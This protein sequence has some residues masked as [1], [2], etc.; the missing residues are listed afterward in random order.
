MKIISIGGVVLDDEDLEG[1]VEKATDPPYEINVEYRTR[2]QLAPSIEDYSYQESERNLYIQPKF[3]T[4]PDLETINQSVREF[5]AVTG[6]LVEIIGEYQ[7]T[8]YRNDVL[9]RSNARPYQNGFRLRGVFL[10]PAWEATSVTTSS[11]NPIAI[12]GN[13]VVR[14]LITI[15]DGDAV[16]RT[17]LTITDQT[18]EGID[19][20]MITTAI[21]AGSANDILIVKDGMSVPFEFASNRVYFRVGTRIGRPTVVDIYEGSAIN[22]TV[23][24]DAM[25]AGGLTLDSDIASGTFKPSP[26]DPYTHPRS[27][28]MSWL[29]QITTEHD[30]SIPYRFGYEDGT[31]KLIDSDSTGTQQKMNND[32]DSLVLT[33]PVEMDEISGIEIDLATGFRAGRIAEDSEDVE[34]VMRVIITDADGNLIPDDVREWSDGTVNIQSTYT[35]LHLSQ[36]TWPVARTD[37][38]FYAQWTFGAITFPYT[39]SYETLEETFQITTPGGAKFATGTRWNLD[40][41]PW[42]FPTVAAQFLGCTVE[43]GAT[44]VYY[45]RWA[46]GAFQGADI[47]DLTMSLNPKGASWI[48]DD[49]GDVPVVVH[50]DAGID[51]VIVFQTDWVDPVT[52]EVLDGSQSDAITDDP[53]IG[54]ARAVVKY[55]TRDS[56][57]PITAYSV[58][59]TGTSDGDVTSDPSAGAPVAGTDNEVTITLPTISIPGA[60]QVAIGLEPV[61]ADP[62]EIEWGTLTIDGTIQITTQAGSRPSIG[63]AS[64]AAQRLDGVLANDR[65]GVRLDFDE[66][67]SDDSGLEINASAIGTAQAVRG[68]GGVGPFWGIV[69]SSAGARMFDFLPGDNDWSLDGDMA[70]ATVEFQYR[71]RLAW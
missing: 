25:D 9:I 66:A 51:D 49:S 10:E 32:M 16:D 15:T 46:A 36:L 56:E 18:G 45:L 54:R 30:R 22:N 42:E 5:F 47:P 69:A 31:I 34:R 39:Y 4:S 70:G 55:W 28:A 33:S 68:A 20:W 24:A 7:G 3:D 58:E 6:E 13:H 19:S 12:S 26:S 52:L 21:T 63:V 59:L 14:P 29:P 8:Q 2:S 37:Y 60:V 53:L 61:A 65:T 71:E 17:R 62:Q 11:A 44:G 50:G 35:N 57:N 40:Y 23:K 27:A 43:N 67:Y 1:V 64:T 48:V 38:P 41:A